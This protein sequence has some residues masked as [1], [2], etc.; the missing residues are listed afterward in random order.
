M[1]CREN[2][3]RPPLQVLGKAGSVKV[4]GR[5]PKS[6]LARVFNFKLGCF[7]MCTIARP[8]HAWPSL[9]LKTRLRFSPI[10]LSLSMSKVK[11]TR[12]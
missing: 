11:N 5:E 1:M 7:V 4:N 8:I 10:R 6:C 3:P 12:Q 2:S 9:E